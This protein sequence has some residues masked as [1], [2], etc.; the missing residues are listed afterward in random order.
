MTDQRQP[1]EAPPE[2]D[3]AKDRILDAVLAVLTSD[4]VSGV[5]MRAVARE[6]GV[7]VGL[8]N[9]HFDNKTTLI[10]AALR[11]IGEQDARLV[12]PA[13]DLDP[14]VALRA[15]LRHVADP[16]FLQTSYLR[17]RIQLWSLANVDEEFAV[18]NH[19]AQIRYR[20]GL[21]DLIA[22][23]RPELERGEVERRAGDILV[24]QNGIWLTSVLIVDPDVVERGLV[25]CEQIAF[26]R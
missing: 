1:E 12:A 20:S 15:A 26:E 17:L 3:R 22:T 4:G 5:S 16:E 23:A 24:I 2:K 25:R 10:A 13:D 19:D 8:A 21:A 7:S 11:R 18:I 9:Y 6:A 14:A